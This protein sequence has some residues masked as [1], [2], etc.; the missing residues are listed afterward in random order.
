MERRYAIILFLLALALR[1]GYLLDMRHS[2]YFSTLVLDAEEYAFLA[3][4]FAEGHW[5]AG[6]QNTYVHGP[7]YPLVLAFFALGGAGH[8]AVRVFQALLGSGSCVLVY[9]AARAVFP[10]P[11]P[12]LAGLLTAGYWMLVFYCGELSTPTL[13]VFLELLLVV[14]LLRHARRPS[15]GQAA[16]AGLLLGLLVATHN[17]A[18]LLTP[19]ILWGV[20]RGARS[21]HRPCQLL[22]ACGLALA[23]VLS[24]FA[25]RNFL[26]QGTPLPFQGAWSF[27]LGSNPQADGTPY[28]RQGLDWQRLETLP[29]QAGMAGSPADKA[30]YYLGAALRFIRDHPGAYLELLYR[31]F[32]LFW[33]AFEVPVSEDLAYYQAHSRLY[34][35]LVLDFGLLAPLALVGLVWGWRRQRGYA[36]LAGLVLANLAT[37]LLFTVCARYRLPAVPLL[38]IFAAEGL[39]QCATCLQARELRRGGLLLLSLGAAFA[40]VHTGVN[41]REVDPVRSAWL[42]GHVHLRNGEYG[43]AEQ[44]LLQ[45]L[46]ESGEDA[47][48]Y[49]SLG[50]ARQRLGRDAEAEAAYLR[51]LAIAP[52]Y[53]R[54]RLNLGE[55]YLKQQRLPEAQAALE[56]ALASDPRPATQYEG[57]YHLGQLQLAGHQYA[58][59][60]QAFA[61][62]LQAQRRPEGYYALA[63]VC[64]QLGRIEEEMAHLQQAVALDPDFAPAQR[65]LGA[66]YLQQGAYAAAEAALLTALRLDPGA[67]T[68]Y[69]NLAVVY[70]RTGREAE[71]RAAFAA[72]QRLQQETGPP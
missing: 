37:G 67:A 48:I 33:H 66:L 10:R 9:W 17:T 64:Q 36:L 14:L 19:V 72:A 12:L 23:A 55:L 26:A 11:A 3:A 38:L 8:T 49:N 29:Y 40:L 69:Y 13:T 44:A 43:R 5:T 18:L 25:T 50:A 51:A 68:A 61:L 70:R 31:K 24:L 54:P 62:A 41:P 6:A 39:R 71:A 59:A 21:H 52:D 4:A 27:Y 57:R 34:C 35:F 15:L 16:G 58:L 46:E 60:Y 22:L 45:A 65:N 63:G 1:L 53:A 28:A 30:R 56:A 47:D 20:W 7:L 2:P 32:R 42:Q